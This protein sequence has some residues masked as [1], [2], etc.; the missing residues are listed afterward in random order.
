MKPRAAHADTPRSRRRGAGR[1]PRQRRVRVVVFRLPQL[2]TAAVSVFVRS[3]SAHESAR[4]ERH[5]PRRRAHGVQGHA[6]RATASA[7][8]STPSGWAPRSTPTPTRTT[9][10]STCAAWRRDALRLRAHARRHRA[11]TAPS[12]R[13]SSSASARCILQRVRRGRGRRAVDRLRAV[14]PRLLRRA[15]GRAAGDR[16]PRQ[17]RALHARRP[18]SATCSA[19]YTG[20]NIV[21]GVAGDVDPD[22]V[23]AAAAGGVRRHAA[24]QPTTGSRRPTT[25][26]AS[27][28]AGLAG[29][30][31]AHVVLGFPIPAL[32]ATTTW[33]AASPRPLFGEGMSS[34]LLDRLRER[35]GLVYHA[36]CSADVLSDCAASS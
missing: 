28:R 24:R 16:Q 18:A 1:D 2:A 26:A 31:Q 15:P 12:P 32:R 10:R 9:P 4:H 3:G 19:S 25:S 34:P 8:T 35:R 17:H 5:Q 20:A 22:A 7:S 23:V 14:R 6:P 33:P 27:A 11:A 30:S 21:V 29:S 13:T 36:D